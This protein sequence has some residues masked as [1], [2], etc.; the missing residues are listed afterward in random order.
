MFAAGF[1]CR[2]VNTSKELK[3][4]AIAALVAFFLATATI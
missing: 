3:W 1:V 2:D 4:A